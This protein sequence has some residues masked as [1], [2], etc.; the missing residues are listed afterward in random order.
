[1]K[2]QAAID[3]FHQIIKDANMLRPI[4][5]TENYVI[6]KTADHPDICVGIDIYVMPKLF[7]M[8]VPGGVFMARGGIVGTSPDLLGE[9][10][11]YRN[12]EIYRTLGTEKP[13]QGA[14]AMLVVSFWLAVSIGGIALTGN[15]K[16]IVHAVRDAISNAVKR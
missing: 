7:G 9:E 11:D 5:S 8:K 3:A 6:E 10:I 13:S 16:Y 15:G 2:S 12:A 1:M 14:K 4:V